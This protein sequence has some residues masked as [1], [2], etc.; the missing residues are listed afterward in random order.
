[1][2]DLDA[3]LRGLRDELTAAIPLP[4]VERIAGRARTR[5]RLQVGAL[6]AVIAVVVAVP[7]V[8]ALPV[9][10]T[11]ARPNPA[12]TSYV[13][14]FADAKHGYALTRTCERGTEVCT[15]TLYRTADGGETW[16]SRRLPL[17]PGDGFWDTMYVLGPDEVT[18]GKP[19]GPE[20]T[21]IFSTDG[22]RSWGVANDLARAGTA[23]LA[24]G[25]LLTGACGEQPY[26]YGGCDVVGSIR[27]DTGQF[28]AAPT[29]PRLVPVQ[30]GPAPTVTGKWWVA[31]V[32]ATR[33]RPVLAVSADDGRTWSTNELTEPVG[34]RWAVVEGD[35]VLYATAAD[36]AGKVA[37]V[38]RSTDD[39]R[40]WTRT[41][42][43]KLKPKD[44]RDD[45]LPTGVGPFLDSRP[46]AAGDGSLI[47]ADMKQTL[48]SDDEGRTF[49]RDGGA[50][51][52]VSWTR[53]GY[54]RTNGG[55]F[56][57]SADGL[58]WRQ[59]TVG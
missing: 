9:W 25:G 46:I 48:V 51:G 22:G 55:S 10:L 12:E 20:T 40:S 4:D 11:A 30:V 1:M 16:Q 29:Q 58:H 47:L 3:D 8:H 27:P 39:G 28:V 41:W 42:A 15:F 56:E 35:G 26:Q 19:V 49:R 32:N 18:I 45:Y 50:S 38:W 52:W 57:L 54:L 43:A 34:R 24:P 23:P 13:V 17:A 53:G 31:G 33:D 14:D 44:P 6:L 21:R 2:S 36:D 59:F 37:G 7:V 5:R